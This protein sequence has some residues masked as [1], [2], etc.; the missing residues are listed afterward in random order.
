MSDWKVGE[1]HG[2]YEV[3]ELTPSQAKFKRLS[4]GSIVTC[5]NIFQA[6]SQPKK[7]KAD[8]ADKPVR[9]N[10]NPSEDDLQAELA[11]VQ[12]RLAAI[13]KTKQALQTA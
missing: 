9:K 6:K 7:D 12:A 5:P 3:V 13:K 11:R 4:D 2:D 8:K 1:I 10:K